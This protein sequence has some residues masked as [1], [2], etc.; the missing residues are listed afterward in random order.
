MLE[1]AYIQQKLEHLNIQRTHQEAQAKL[2]QSEAIAEK[3]LRICTKGAARSRE[4]S[5]R[6][7]L[8]QT[9]LDRLTSQTNVQQLQA[10]VEEKEERFRYSQQE[11]ESYRSKLQHTKVW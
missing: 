5:S 2:A 1:R 4:A 7:R 9:K 10:T 8:L 3:A 6:A 11:A